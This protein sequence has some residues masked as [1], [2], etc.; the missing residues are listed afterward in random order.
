MAEFLKSLKLEK[1]CSQY[2]AQ[3]GR[4]NELGD[5]DAAV[6]LIL[7]KLRFE[8]GD[9]DEGGRLGR[10]DRSLQSGGEA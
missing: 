10:V 9:Y 1:A 6:T 4:R 3:M 7:E 2:G 8:D 5:P